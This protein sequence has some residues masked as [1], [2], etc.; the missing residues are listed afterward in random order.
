M[1]K[2]LSRRTVLRGLGV[3]LAL[4]Y[5]E[6]MLP[7]TAKAQAAADKIP[8]RAAFL[9]YGI[10]MN[11][12]EFFPDGEGADAQLGRILQPL[13]QFKSQLTAL[14]GTYLEHGGSHQGDY[15]ILTGNQGKK[16]TGIYNSISAD[17]I[18]AQQLGQDTRFA[19][20]QM[21]I[22]RGTGYGGV[23]NTMSWNRSG[24]PLAAENDPSAI[25]RKLFL[26]ETARE[27]LQRDKDNRRRGSILDLVM[28]QAKS[29]ESRVSKN[30]KQKLDEYLTSVRETETQLERNIDWS[31]KPKPEANLPDLGDYSRRYDPF[32]PNAD[33]PSYAK[34]MYDLMALAFQTDSTRVITYMVR[35][36]GGETFECHET[37]NGFHALTHHGNDPKRLD[38]L[39]QVDVVNMRFLAG[40]LERLQSIREPD[41]KT[42]LDRTMV[43]TASG[44]GIDHS[45]DRLPVILVG[46]S[47]LGVK[48]QTYVKLPDN[49]PLS[50]VWR[51]MLDRMGVKI[52]G[53]FQDSTGLVREI[54]A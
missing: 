4:P 36:E 8:P 49:T 20:L 26:V 45:R 2:Q 17:Q 30:D 12:R 23:M 28:G 52:E 19:S 11:M 50:N 3:S 46:G 54:V 48:H 44:M 34:L 41:G 47:A 1:T 16:P 29:M 31:N 33:Y 7:R 22:R 37:T 35:T 39:A 25:F 18:A 10:G 9:G 40:F 42:L 21:S 24:I 13:N 51:T 5:L 32:A 27:R 43:A 14:S 15:V 6:A 38:E 53:E